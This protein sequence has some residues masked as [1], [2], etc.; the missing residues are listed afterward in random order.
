M[1]NNI[2][3]STLKNNIYPIIKKLK[4]KI[5]CYSFIYQIT[6]RYKYRSISEHQLFLEFFFS[7]SNQHNIPLDREI[8]MTRRLFCMSLMWSYTPIRRWNT[9]M[10]K[11]HTMRFVGS[12]KVLPFPPHVWRVTWVSARQVI[13][14]VLMRQEPLWTLAMEKW[15]MTELEKKKKKKNQYHVKTRLSEE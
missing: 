6:L 14:P 12:A 1:R 4:A 11:W 15:K 3:T 7:P 10:S 9:C 8:Y 2:L 5:I 13:R